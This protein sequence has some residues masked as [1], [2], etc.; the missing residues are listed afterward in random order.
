MSANALL[1]FSSLNYFC[2]IF[3][4][5]SINPPKFIISFHVVIK[6]MI[7]FSL[8]DIPNFNLST[9]TNHKGKTSF[10]DIIIPISYIF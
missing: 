3:N 2:G 9:E 6:K 5:F 1:Y 8:T 10:S 4:I 7:L